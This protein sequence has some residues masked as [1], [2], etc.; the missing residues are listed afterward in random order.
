MTPPRALKMYH[1]AST[2]TAHETR[3]QSWSGDTIEQSIGL[4]AIQT[5]EPLFLR[6]LPREGRILESGCG[7]G[8]WVFYLQRKGYT[9][10]G[11][12]LS[13][14][15]LAAAKAYDPGVPV[16]KDD[17]L[18]SSYPDGTFDAAISLGVVEHFEEGPYAALAE[19]HRLLRTGGTLCIS[20][21]TQNL[22]RRVATNHMK[23][24]YRFLRERRG[25][26]YIFEEYRFSRR[27]FTHMLQ[28]AGFDIITA[29]PDDFVPPLNMGLSV[30]FPF[31]RHPS[32]RWELNGAG[33]LLR[34]VTAAFSPWWTCAG[35]FWVCRK[36]TASH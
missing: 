31:F 29:V 3:G 20:V 8:R 22:M 14:P 28:D 26:P 13:E 18:R 21:P 24:L 4:C 1:A 10:E 11:I 30:D 27:Q 36:R 32:R 16:R 35:T 25:E 34:S 6:H 9:I 15:A 12:D 5:I 23:R 19:L 7:L 33:R 2:S 17:V